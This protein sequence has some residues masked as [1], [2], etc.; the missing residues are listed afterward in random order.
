MRWSL[1][2]CGDGLYNSTT[3]SFEECDRSATPPQSPE[4]TYVYPSTTKNYRYDV[5][6]DMTTRDY[7]TC[8][9]ICLSQA[10]DLCGDGYESNGPYDQ[11]DTGLYTKDSREECDD[12]NN[13]DGDGCSST[14][15]VEPEWECM[16]DAGTDLWGIGSCRPLCGNGIVEDSYP[17][18]DGINTFYEEC[19]LGDYNSDGDVYY[20]ACSTTC[21]K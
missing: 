12:G 10:V 20:H 2:G 13:R 9:D 8:S 19:D 17:D 11:W 3:Y 7:Y 1:Q 6:Y 4:N 18:D 16:N 21:K 5:W 15:T 14:C